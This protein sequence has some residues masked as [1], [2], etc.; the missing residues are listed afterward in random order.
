MDSLKAVGAFSKVYCVMPPINLGYLAAVLEKEGHEVT[1]IDEAAEGLSLAEIIDRLRR[2]SPGMIGMGCLTQSA[3]HVME[4]SRAIAGAFPGLP[5]V[6]GNTHADYFAEPI[7]R[8]G[9]ADVVVH[10]EGEYTFAHLARTFEHKGDLQEV[11]GI[12][13]RDG[14]R[15]VR[16][17]PRTMQ[18]D[19]NRIPYPAWHLFPR[20]RYRLFTF[21][22]IERPGTLILG[23]RGCPFK[24]NY[25]SL[26]IMGHDRRR[27]TLEDMAD[28]ME[29]MHETYGYRQIS[30]IDPIFPF[31]RKEGLEFAQLLVK[32][33]LNRKIVWTTETRV[34]L[35]TPEL[36]EAL[37]EAGC[38]RVMYGFEVGSEE[39]LDAIDKGTTI[40]KARRAAK[41]T[42]EAGM[43]IIGFFMVGCPGETLESI[44]RTVR[45][46]HELDVDFAKFNVFVPYPGTEIFEEFS[47]KNGGLPTDWVR[48][49][50]YPTGG[51]PPVYIPPG[52]SVEQL[53]VAQRRAHRMFYLRPKMIARHMFKIR[54]IPFSHMVY[55]ALGLLGEN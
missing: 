39:S 46:S 51:N 20:S 33:G 49:T 40:D 1:V 37:R 36:L 28:E 8:E 6:M 54:T 2:A 16:T 50:S 44:D 26:L 52:L 7:L 23:S 22:E 42:K 53:I 48:Y 35:V 15:I 11:E 30:F 25:C 41:W 12:S 3:P 43:E 19:L 29:F 38:R 45:F 27:R 55:G 47:K 34:D 21:A 10:N 5:R 4:I 14:D 18:P 17:P 24:C 31:S 32:R 13:Y 9:D